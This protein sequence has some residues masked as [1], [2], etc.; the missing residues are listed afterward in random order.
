MKLYS[1]NCI[2]TSM[3]TDNNIQRNNYEALRIGL[4]YVYKFYDD[5]SLSLT[6]NHYFLFHLPHCLKINSE[7][8]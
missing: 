6:D 1:H 3:F 4:L 2:N 7:N 5:H 8:I